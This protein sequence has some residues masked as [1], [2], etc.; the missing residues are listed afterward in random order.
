MSLIPIVIVII[1]AILGL[2]SIVSVLAHMFQKAG[3]DEALVIYGMGGNNVITGGGRIVWPLVQ[4]CKRI[5]LALMS[6]DIAPTNDLYTNQGVAVTVEAVSQIKIIDTNE[7]IKTAAI[8]FLSKSFEDRETMIKQ[9]M[10]GH[11]R[12]IVGTLKVEEIVKDPEMVQARMLA[13]CQLD[14]SKMGLEVRSFTIKNVKDANGYIENMG[15]PEIA[16]VF[17][18]AQIAEAIAL[19]ETETFKASANRDAAIAKTNAEQATVTAQTLSQSQQAENT[20]DLNLKKAKYDAEVE[21]A[22]ADKENAY[23]LRTA[24]LKQNLTEQEWK[25]AEIE[26]QGQVK[27]ANAEIERKQKELEA[28]IIKP[29]EAQARAIKIENQAKAE[30][31]AI[32]TKLENQAK[33]EANALTI[34]LENEAKAEATRAVG[35][36]EAEIIKAKGIAEAETIQAK[37]EAFANYSQAAILDKLLSGIPELAKAIASPLSNVEKITVVSTGGDTSGMG[38]ITKDVTNMMAQVPEVI[39]ALTGVNISDILNKLGGLKK[40][41]PVVEDAT[42]KP[43]PNLP[44]DVPFAPDIKE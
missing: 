11:L 4:T 14:L 28:S 23:N 3:P 24:E 27:V 19:K 22:R 25:I 34:K 44:E 39:E 1:I 21:T 13:T 43:L 5:S 16:R 20:K 26:R 40:D 38:K 32:V 8:Q 29:A 7:S 30:A 37:A 12:G 35:I 10:E 33:A 42:V 15:K 9:V 6:F 41:I 18:E 17:K 31:N 2:L 36:S